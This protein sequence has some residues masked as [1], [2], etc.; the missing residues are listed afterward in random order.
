[1]DRQI[2]NPAVCEL[3]S[4]IRFLIARNAKPA[5]I[6][7]QIYGVYGENAMSDS[8]VRRWVRIFNEGRISVHDEEVGD[9]LS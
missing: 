7:R 8:M 3:R 1:M 2:E 5:D 6:Y 9:I 4:V